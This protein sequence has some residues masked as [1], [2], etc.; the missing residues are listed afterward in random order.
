MGALDG[1]P[2]AVRV[3]VSR[4]LQAAAKIAGGRVELSKRLGVPPHFIGE[5]IAKQADAPDEIVHA[6]IEIILGSRR[7]GRG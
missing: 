2:D 3:Q 5:W 7:P 6:A 4:V 1:R